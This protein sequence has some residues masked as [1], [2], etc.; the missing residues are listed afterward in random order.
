MRSVPQ[1]RGSCRAQRGVGV[2][3]LRVRSGI[4]VVLAAALLL[5]VAACSSDE[6]SSTSAASSSNAPLTASFRGVTAT[7]IKIGIAVVDFACIA[8]FIDFNQGDARKI[9]QAMVD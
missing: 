5:S 9:M 3:R 2:T 4:A 6:K 1:V 8:Q 7:E